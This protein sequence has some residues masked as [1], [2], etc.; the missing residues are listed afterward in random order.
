MPD[1]FANRLF[2]RAFNSWHLAIEEKLEEY[3]HESRNDSP[4]TLEVSAAQYYGKH[5]PKFLKLAKT[6]FNIQHIKQMIGERQ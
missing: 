6:W 4:I 1:E 3:M 5:D 2:K